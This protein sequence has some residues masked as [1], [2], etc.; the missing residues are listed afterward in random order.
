M[1]LTSQDKLKNSLPNKVKYMC[2]LELSGS[3]GN[4]LAPLRQPNGVTEPENGPKMGPRSLLGDRFGIKNPRVLDLLRQ[5]KKRASN[6]PNSPDDA[7]A[8]ASENVPSE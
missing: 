7:E 4:L 2:H 6:K 5:A 8:G 3:Q 1:Y